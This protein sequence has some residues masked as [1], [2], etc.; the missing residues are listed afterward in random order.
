MGRRAS[1]V[2]IGQ[3]VVL[4]FCGNG[5]KGRKMVPI[6]W[7]NQSDYQHRRLIKFTLV[8]G[9]FLRSKNHLKYKI[10]KKRLLLQNTERHHK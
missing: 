4:N 1:S 6:I 9:L 10:E 5:C 8:N 2:V 3:G 7:Y